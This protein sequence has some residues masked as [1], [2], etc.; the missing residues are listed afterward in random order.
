MSRKLSAS[1][2]RVSQNLPRIENEIFAQDGNLYGFA[3][4]AEIFQRAA[5]KFSFRED[6]ERG[7][8]GGFERSSKGATGSNGSRRTPRRETQA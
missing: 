2:A 3:G 6:G 7:G 1:F 4:V 8:S 5:E